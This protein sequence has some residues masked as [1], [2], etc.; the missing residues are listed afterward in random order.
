VFLSYTMGMH[1]QKKFGCFPARDANRNW[2][3]SC[4][5]S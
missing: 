5:R 1:K 2:R 3:P 4:R